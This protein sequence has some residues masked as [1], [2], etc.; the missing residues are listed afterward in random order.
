MINSISSGQELFS[1]SQVLEK[2]SFEVE[3]QEHTGQQVLKRI[4]QL[5]CQ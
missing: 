5:V 1:C 3:D 2:V 4:I